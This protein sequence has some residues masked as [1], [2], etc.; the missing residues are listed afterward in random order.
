MKSQQGYA[1]QEL[2]SE[3]AMKEVW[4]ALTKQI[5]KQQYFLGIQT[6]EPDFQ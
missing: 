3:T 5:L 4:L 2:A 6:D 1:K